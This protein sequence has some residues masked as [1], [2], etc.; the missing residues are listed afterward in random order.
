MPPRVGPATV[1]PAAPAPTGITYGTGYV[2]GVPRRIALAPIPNGKRMRSDAAAAFNRMHAAARAA[3][4]TLAPESGFR[5]MQEQEA[6]WRAHR[7]GRG[8]LAARPGFSNHQ[9]GIAVDIN[10][11]GWRSAQSR[12]LNQHAQE[13]GF[14][15]TVPSEPWH[16]EYRP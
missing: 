10:V 15:R 6:L 2:N 5:S 4:I 7:S 8:N 1:Q 16:W 14:R 9:G 11:N 3:G 12:W 13:F